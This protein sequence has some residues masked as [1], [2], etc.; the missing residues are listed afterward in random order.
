MIE[1]L[2]HAVYTK[3]THT[4]QFLHAISHYHPAQ[5]NRILITFINTAIHISDSGNWNKE[6][7]LLQDVLRQNSYSDMQIDRAMKKELD[8]TKCLNQGEGCKC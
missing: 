8:E 7:T 5:K 2:G 6:R 3:P 1:S 4:N